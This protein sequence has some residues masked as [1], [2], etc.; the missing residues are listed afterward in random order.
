MVLYNPLNGNVI[1]GT[2]TSTSAFRSR[3]YRRVFFDE[4][5]AL[6]DGDLIRVMKSINMVSRAPALVSTPDGRGHFSR[7]ALG[8]VVTTTEWGDPEPQLGW[9]RYQCTPDM[10]PRKTD[11]VMAR[12]RA[13]LTQDEQEQELYGSFDAGAVG[14]IWPEFSRDDHVYDWEQWPQTHREIRQ[15]G[16]WSLWESWD[17]G[18]SASLTAVAWALEQAGV[19]YL[20]DYRCWMSATPATIAK[21]VA[22]A[23]YATADNPGGIKP[24]YRV[25]DPAM[26]IKNQLQGSWKLYLAEHGIRLQAMAQNESREAS[27]M[28]VRN[29]IIDGR[30]FCA[31]A[32]AKRI[33]GTSLPTLVDSIINYSRYLPRG[34]DSVHTYSGRPDIPPA[35]DEYSH[36][37]DCVQYIGD[38]I[39]VTK[40][41]S[42]K[43]TRAVYSY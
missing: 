40:K 27:V 21:D 7:I 43:P 39:W 37:A 13:R 11:D 26:S 41:K 32:C 18:I 38:W 33:P 3:R 23:G 14:R 6:L 2:S 22:E 29:A 9:M 17:F 5:A 16:R 30:L 28:R 12:E 20:L 10:D 34:K 4:V 36:L 31:P 35:K 24:D 19:L 8:E 15:A 1:A 25:G 42:S